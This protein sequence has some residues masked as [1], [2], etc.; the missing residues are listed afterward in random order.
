MELLHP[1]PP[2]AE[3]SLVLELS[4]PMLGASMLW[5]H[6]ALA[7]RRRPRPVAES[8]VWLDTAG[9][10]LAGRN[11]ALRDPARGPRRLC[12]LMP[13]DGF[14]LP[15]MPAAPD[16]VFPP[17]NEPEGL[18]DT[19]L[20]T[21]ARWSGRLQSA[22]ADEAGVALQL[23]CGRIEAGASGAEL[24]RLT[25]TGPPAAVL[26]LGT[27]LAEAV[28]LLP[29]TASLDEAARALAAGVPARPIRRG[30]PDLGGANTPD[31]ALSLAIAHLTEVLLAQAPLAQAGSGPEGVH[32]LRVAARRLRS[33]LK[34]FRKSH[35]GPE[36]QALENELRTLAGGLTDAREW[37]VF[38]GGLGADLSA[39]VGKERRWL[40]LLRAAG[41]RRQ[42]AYDSLAAMLEGPGFRCL[43]WRALRLAALRDWEAAPEARNAPL[44]PWA[45]QKLQKR[46]RRLK[47]DARSI[48]D[49]SDAALHELRLEAKKLRYASEL[50]A[51]LWPGRTAKRF[52]KRL[53]ALQ[54]AL[55]LSND[56]VVARERV[57]SLAG[58]GG[59]PTWAIGLAEGWALAAAQ[60]MRPRALKTWRR[61]A[62]RDPFWAGD[63]PSKDAP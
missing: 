51:P 16:T 2:A 40:R 10:R 18:E 45:A 52:L 22:P 44:R 38:L 11:L 8:W 1:D 42:E 63:L 37:D 33:C 55:G 20:E 61:F 6:P 19:P 30:A 17:G 58:P 13:P 60:D 29:V 35:H 23:R 15:G 4:L 3:A 14:R 50:F 5:R 32:Q 49:A 28:P 34:L 9:R 54:E 27:A 7:G 25:L 57:A 47:K 62:R 21:L 12:V 43:V 26:A 48:E 56:A 59:A 41:R 39:A 36:L 46:R 31:D 53:S 24:A